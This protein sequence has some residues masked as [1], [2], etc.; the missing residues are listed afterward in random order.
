VMTIAP[1]ADGRQIAER[2]LD[3]LTRPLVIEGA[4][5]RVKASAGLAEGHG[6]P[7]GIADLLRRAD[8]AMYAA[9]ARGTRIELYDPELDEANRTRLEIVQDLDA[10]LVHNQFV[11]HYQPKVDVQTG[12][13]VGAEAL[14][15]WQHPTRG[16][17]Y[18]DAFLPTVEQCGLMS[19]LT[20]SVL[21]SAVKQLADWHADGLDISLAVNLSAS[22]LLDERLA[23]RIAELLA[24]LAIPVN[25]L[26]LEITESV[27]MTDPDRARTVLEQLRRLGLRI[28]VDDYGTGYCALAYLRDLPVDELKID[29]SFIT[30]ITADPRSAAIV[31]STIE[32]AH[33]LDLTVVAEG[34]EQRNAL[35]VLSS[36]NCDFAQGYHFSRPLT[37]DA[38][39]A[40]VQAR[41][42]NTAP[43]V[44][45]S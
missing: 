5:V 6:S 38:F 24:E 36:F 42:L 29:R 15:R 4:R 27:L 44:P 23:E 19:A 25:A 40:W 16:L 43:A 33:A 8:M 37:A 20:R 39:A 7:V 9:K 34:V 2:I 11:L 41:V 31:R 13:T 35:N 32:L 17:L 10:A 28:A 22:D 21:E 45:A 30:H 1:D 12:A 3:R 26:E 14:V 18:P